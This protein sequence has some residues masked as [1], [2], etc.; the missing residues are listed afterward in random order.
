MHKLRT[1]LAGLL[2]LGLAQPAWAAELKQHVNLH[3]GTCTGDPPHW[4]I[5]V[6]ENTHG[7]PVQIVEVSILTSGSVTAAGA[8]FQWAFLTYRQFGEPGYIWL[9]WADQIN[10][11][12]SL[13]PGN[14]DSVFTWKRPQATL[15]VQPGEKVYLH[16]LCSPPDY[17]GIYSIIDYVMP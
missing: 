13:N 15:T 1:L 9:H 7:V 14:Y 12:P 4:Q 17:Y 10:K 8:R 16:H 6:W 11:T 3:T 2:A 5:L